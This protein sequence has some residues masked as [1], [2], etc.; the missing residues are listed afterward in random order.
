MSIYVLIDLRRETYQTGTTSPSLC[1]CGRTPLQSR[2]RTVT[3]CSTP[4]QPTDQAPETELG[5]NCST[6]A[7]TTSPVNRRQG[8]V[9]LQAAYQILAQLEPGLRHSGGQRRNRNINHWIYK[10]C[11]LR[12][13]FPQVNLAGI[14]HNSTGRA[15]HNHQLKPV[16]SP[17]LQDASLG[18]GIH[19]QEPLVVALPETHLLR[20]KQFRCIHS[21][22]NLLFCFRAISD[23]VSTIKSSV[24]ASKRTSARRSCRRQF[25]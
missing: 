4:S 17:P 20:L 25:R 7:Q 10:F 13:T 8:R 9:L 2:R 16:L 15:L 21:L 22:M 3:H 19:L 14:N 6:V 1:G 23:P 18:L 5:V 24:S 12:V 11:C